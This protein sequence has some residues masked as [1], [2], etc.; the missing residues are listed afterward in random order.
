MNYAEIKK[1]RS[2][3]TNFKCDCGG[4]LF[5]WGEMYPVID[6]RIIHECRSCGFETTIRQSEIERENNGTII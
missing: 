3:N 2:K 1:A 6:P 5:T 4:V